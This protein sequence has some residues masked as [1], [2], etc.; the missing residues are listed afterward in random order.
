MLFRSKDTNPAAEAYVDQFPK[1]KT[2]QAARFVSFVAG[3]LLGVLAIGSLID[4][5]LI[6]NFEIGFGLNVLTSIAILTTIVSVSRGM[7]QDDY[8]VYDPEWSISNVIQ[9]THYFP[10]HWVGKLHS[11][12]VSCRAL[13]C[14]R[15]T[16]C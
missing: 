16:A 13:L 7:L 1:E 3:S 9:H 8:M 10:D 14:V 11:D 5:E 4:Y 15:T 12:D 6:K 2:A